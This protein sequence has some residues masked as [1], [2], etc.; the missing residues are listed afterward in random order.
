M[1][2]TSFIQWAAKAVA[3]LVTPIVFT[4]LAWASAKILPFEYDPEVV[5]TVILSAVT[6]VVV[7]LVRNK[8]R[9]L[10]A[11]EVLLDRIRSR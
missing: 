4:V 9:F 8:D 10:D 3:A 6:A 5:R 7:F 2:E 11:R 1:S